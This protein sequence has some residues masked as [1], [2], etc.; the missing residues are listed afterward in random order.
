M[1]KIICFSRQLLRLFFFFLDYVFWNAL[2]IYFLF[3]PQF[4]WPLCSMAYVKNTIGMLNML[5]LN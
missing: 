3:L 1:E 4:Y 2:S 5:F